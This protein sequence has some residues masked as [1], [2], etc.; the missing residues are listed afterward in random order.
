MKG[1]I[2]GGGHRQDVTQFLDSEISSPT[3][4]ITSVMIG[5][6]M[7]AHN[8]DHVMT[9]DHTAAYL[10]ADMKG[11]PVEMMLSNEVSDMLCEIDPSN[12]QYMRNNG[13]IYVRLRKALYGCVQ[14]AVLWYNELKGTLVKMGFT[15]NPYD[16]CSFTRKRGN[17]IDRILVY[18]DDLLITS[19]CEQSLDDIDKTL[20]DKYGGVTSKKGRAHDYLGIKWDFSIKGEVTMSMGGYINDIFSKYKDARPR[21]TPANDNLFAV[22]ESSPSLSKDKQEM[23]HSLVM[24]LHYLAKR[25]RPDILTA[26]SWCASRVLAPTEEDEKK[27]DHIMGYLYATKNNVTTLRI[28]DNFKLK[29]YVDA[30]Y[31]VYADAKS[32][33]GVVLML[34]DAVIYVKSSKQ[35]I[36]TR[37]STESELVAIS[38]S[39]SQMLWTREYMKEA[40]IDIGPVTLFQDNMSTICLA[41]KGRSTSERTRHIK[42]RY[43]FIHHYIDTNEIAI[44]Y[45]PTSDM[46][47]DIMTKPLHGA[48]F[49]KLCAALSGRKFIE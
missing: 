47:A 36:V 4:A 15:E 8:N 22:S 25:V 24:T 1:R 42:I 23:Y 34:G 41:S 49:N 46:I 44:E 10:N 2:V 9:L 45:M 19:D 31:A 29:A 27:L 26:V 14:S 6:S 13:K 17:S 18:V 16:I 7:A 11:T 3:V 21:K 30:S 39:L 28:G 32:V 48:L 5:A 40:G 43:F 38:D 35:K 37:S 12:K 20:R 33:T